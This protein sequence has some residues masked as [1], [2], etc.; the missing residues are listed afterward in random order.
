MQNLQ[1]QDPAK[2]SY[3]T[4][5]AS[6]MVSVEDHRR[7]KN[8]QERRKYIR[9]NYCQTWRRRNCARSLGKVPQSN[10]VALQTPCVEYFEPIQTLSASAEDKKPYRMPNPLIHMD[11]S[12]TDVGKLRKENVSVHFGATQ[13]QITLHTGCYFVAGNSEPFPFACVSDS[14]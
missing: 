7:E 2:C 13:A 12:E 4:I 11:F 6:K 14:L 10:M 1:M 8:N 9:D 5:A 3:W